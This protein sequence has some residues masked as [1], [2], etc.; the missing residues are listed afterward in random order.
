MYR[1]SY[2][3][4]VGL[5]VIAGALALVFLAFK[6][7]GLSFKNLGN[8]SYTI[9]ANF[10]DIGALKKNAAIRI[11]GVKIGEVSRITLNTNTYR[12]K[13][14]L[15]IQQRYHNIPKDS[16]AKIQTSGILGESFVQIDPGFAKKTL[17]NHDEIARTYSATNLT[18][19]L[20]T[21]ASGN[22]KSGTANK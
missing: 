16:S 14:Y 11:A 19:L 21:F 10:D 12:A 8:Q 5:F 3:M 20:S 6:V 18:S 22:A 15:N 4:I 9:V 13:V 2:E 1:K 7:S 17:N